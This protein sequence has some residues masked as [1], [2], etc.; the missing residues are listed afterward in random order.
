MPF[1]SLRRRTNCI[2]GRS[3]HRGRKQSKPLRTCTCR[4]HL[5]GMQPQSSQWDTFNM[6]NLSKISNQS[7]LICLDFKSVCREADCR[8]A[9]P[10]VW[11]KPKFLDS[12]D[13]LEGFVT[14]H[15]NGRL[16]KV[17][18]AEAPGFLGCA[19]LPE[20]WKTTELGPPLETAPDVPSAEAIPLD[21]RCF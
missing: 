2:F 14:F 11:V 12:T 5:P 17:H 9:S 1:I 19:L 3:S 7:N 6:A 13:I 21:K 8:Q 15:R 20:E 18:R 16:S 4:N 10:G